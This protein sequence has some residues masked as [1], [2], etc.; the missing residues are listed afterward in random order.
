MTNRVHAARNDK[1][2]YT[3]TSPPLTNWRVVLELCASS[4]QGV[5]KMEA[6]FFPLIMSI[7][8]CNN[9]GS[10]DDEEEVYRVEILLV[11]LYAFLCRYFFFT[12]FKID[13]L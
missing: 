8:T 4:L 1:H 3:Q 12:H 2:I 9:E 13:F 10:V 5:R 7:P 6:H 11:A